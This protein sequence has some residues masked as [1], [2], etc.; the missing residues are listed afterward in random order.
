MTHRVRAAFTLI[1]L[2][3][4]IAIIA[5]LAAMLLPALARAKL[6]AT[7]ATCLSNQKQLGLA[8][9]MYAT[10]NADKIPSLYPAAVAAPTYGGGFW[11]PPA[12]PG[13]ATA[14]QALP[15]V[16]AA[17]RA[18]NNLIFQYAPNIG[19]YHCPGDVRTKLATLTAG[20]AYDSYSKSQNAGGEYYSPSGTP[21]WGAGATY[22]KLSAIQSTS[23]TFI[24]VEDAGNNGTAGFNVGTWTVQWTLGPPQRFVFVDPVPMYHGNVST[25]AFADGHAENHKWI[26]STLIN[27]GKQ[28]ANGQNVSA[29]TGIP[30]APTMQS[31]RDYSYVYQGYH[32]PNWKP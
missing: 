14:A 23:L 4:V 20:W 1:E 25:F 6:K 27:K 19:V 29:L 10:D 22:R 16:E 18:N 12:I 5:I 7:Q 32:H 8:Y 15:I 9:V 11:G 31:D 3:V 24:F 30:G 26:N 13:G 17:L 21:Y 28:A 2:L